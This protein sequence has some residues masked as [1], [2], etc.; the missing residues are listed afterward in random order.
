MPIL[1]KIFFQTKHIYIEVDNETIL[2]THQALDDINIKT[3]LSA[4]TAFA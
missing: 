4:A 3:E 1:Y 2:K